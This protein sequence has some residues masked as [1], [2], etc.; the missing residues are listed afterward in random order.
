[1]N[2]N[3][4]NILT[5]LGPL[6][7]VYGAKTLIRRLEKAI[8][9]LTDKRVSRR[10]LR[11]LFKGNIHDHIDCSV[12]YDT[13]LELWDKLYNFRFN[14]FS[15]PEGVLAYWKAVNFSLKDCYFPD[16]VTDAW[17][18]KGVDKSLTGAA[19]AAAVRK[20]KAEAIR[21][22]RDFLV[23]YGGGSV[24]Q[25]VQAVVVHILPLMQTKENIE[26]ILHDRLRDG[27]AHGERMA[28]LRGAPQL[29]TWQN[30]D[31]ETATLAYINGVKNAPYPVKLI[32]CALR[33]EDPKVA[34]N[35]AK[36]AGKYRSKGVG[37]F[38]LAADEESNPGVLNWWM[39]PAVLASLFGLQLTI[40]LWETS[41]AKMEDIRALNAFDRI[42]PLAR[43]RISAA[44]LLIEQ[45]NESEEADALISKIIDDTI[46][47]V[48]ASD[49]ID[50]SIYRPHL[51]SR[52]GHGVRGLLQGNRV[53]EVCISSNVVTKQA[54]SFAEHAAHQLFRR[55]KALITINTDG[56]TLIGISGLLDEYVQ[57]QESGWDL[58]DFLIANVI[59]I[60]HSSFS[61][62]E[63]LKMLREC[64]DSYE[65]F[66]Q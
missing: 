22:Y 64:I 14:N 3:K 35:V 55:N 49:D 23:N 24:F 34:W 63:K 59:A 52:L 56:T 30:L 62:R 57:C 32:L 8:P 13:M 44:G 65:E 18:C 39:K 53:C 9:A 48:M 33:H 6:A 5:I 17:R 4:H 43:D 16:A 2:S 1:M 28:E 26:R 50:M 36:I 29:H 47:E 20:S 66:A 31:I 42:V 51:I 19:R 46:A 12:R 10:H 11:Q 25:Y 54:R 21:L 60:S 45:V 61:P 58:A 38:D 15:F 37:C 41:Q 27:V 40:H 7:D